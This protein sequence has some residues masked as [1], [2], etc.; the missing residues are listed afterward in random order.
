MTWIK[1]DLEILGYE[2]EKPNQRTNVLETYH[3]HKGCFEVPEEDVQ[4]DISG[5]L[6][7][8]D[9]EKDKDHKAICDSCGE[10]I[11]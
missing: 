4:Q 5:Y 10:E 6:T 9:L 8:E 11:K 3:Y 2:V 7:K 1:K